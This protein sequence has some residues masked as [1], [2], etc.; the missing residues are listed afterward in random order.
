MLRHRRPLL[1]INLITELLRNETKLFTSDHGW[2]PVHIS[3]TLESF[4]N[5]ARALRIHE[6]ND[7]HWIEES[8]AYVAIACIYIR[9]IAS[10]GAWYQRRSSG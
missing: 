7:Q 1:I 4:P 2:N 6:T 3:P 9:Q 8:I 10:H 5:L